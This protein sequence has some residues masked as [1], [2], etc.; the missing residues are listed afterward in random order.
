MRTAL[1]IVL[2]I[3]STAALWFAPN[4]AAA[5]RLRYVSMHGSDRASGSSA[6]PW[7]TIGRAARSAR[8]GDVVV[9]LPGIYGGFGRKTEWTASGTAGNPITFVGALGAARPT[10]LGYNKIEGSH[11]RIQHLAFIGPSGVVNGSEE[12]LVWILGS[13]VTL[14]S[15]EV[16]YAHWHA[17]IYV[18]ASGFV[19]LI[20]NV[21]HDNGNFGD[22]G[23]GN[24]DHGI[25]WDGSNPGLIADNLI[26]HNQANGIQLYPEARGVTIE[27]N[28]I[29]GNGK[30]GVMI[31][32]TASNNTVV[33]N[34]VAN[35]PDNSIRSYDLGGTSNLVENNLVWNN[36]SGNIGTSV[37]ALTLV[38]NISANPRFVG[39]HNYRLRRSSPAAGHAWQTPAMVPFDITGAPR[40][41]HPAI[42]AYQMS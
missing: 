42:G 9:V 32:G 22:P 20:A 10:I 14:G 18:T 25:Y 29:V 2:A 40:G 19:S 31:A 6:Q 33:N 30:S 11:L 28:T 23:Q 4:S 24:I 39:P 15:S 5:A 21:I 37:N 13:D 35:N 34:I 41:Q 26:V 16:A 38:H 8:P 27:Q 7:R 17:G 12:V 36:G 1:G 3:T